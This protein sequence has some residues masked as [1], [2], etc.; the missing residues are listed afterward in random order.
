MDE[1]ID[2]KI[3]VKPR[4]TPY[5]NVEVDSSIWHQI[6]DKQGWWALNTQ[7][8][9][10]REGKPYYGIVHGEVI[11]NNGDEGRKVI[12]IAVDTGESNNVFSFGFNKNAD[13]VVFLNSTQN[14]KDLLKVMKIALELIS[15]IPD[16]S[17]KE[18]LS[19]RIQH[20]I[21]KE[22]NPFRQRVWDK[23]I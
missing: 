13:L 5:L 19:L 11:E 10:F 12:S 6:E 3:P 18:E 8:D 21:K 1:A 22:E 15:N 23:I 7:H 14:K 9:Y 4:K 20:E 16:D 2:L 17:L